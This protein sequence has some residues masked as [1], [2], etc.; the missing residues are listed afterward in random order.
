MEQKYPKV[1][2]A[3]PTSFHKNYIAKEYYTLIKNL[4]YPNYDIIADNSPDNCNKELY[5]GYGVKHI[6][7]NPK[8]KD[9]T[10][11]LWESQNNIRNHFLDGDYR[12]LLFIE[13]DLLPPRDIIERLLEHKKPVV[14]CPYFIYKGEDAMLMNQ[15]IDLTYNPGT[16]RNFT[17]EESFAKFDGTLKQAYSV[18]FGCTIIKRSVVAQIPFR[19]AGVI[20]DDSVRDNHIKSHADSW[21]YGDCFHNNIPVFLDTSLVIPHYNQDWRHL[22]LSRSE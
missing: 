10:M 1:L 22:T 16:T 4:S 6:W 12:F 2:V 11:F 17:S 21:F 18:G 13:T 9:S 5:E 7:N 15:H 19:V 3:A 20:Q 14:G 8:G